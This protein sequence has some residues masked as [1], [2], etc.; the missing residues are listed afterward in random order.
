MVNMYYTE[1]GDKYKAVL[2]ADCNFD[3]KV[4]RMKR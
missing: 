3:I 4:Q 1:N 2:F